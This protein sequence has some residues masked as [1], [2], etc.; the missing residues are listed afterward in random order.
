PSGGA[1]D[2][3]CGLHERN[4][5]L[6]HLPRRETDGDRGGDQRDQ[7]DAD[8]AGAD[9]E[10]GVR[11][12]IAAFICLISLP[13]SAE[14]YGDLGWD[15]PEEFVR[16][17]QTH[18]QSLSVLSYEEVQPTICGTY[19]GSVPVVLGGNQLSVYCA[20]FLNAGLVE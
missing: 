19:Q 15:Y 2:G 20:H 18:N 14:E 12:W 10:G 11:D 6:P 9:G 1:G 8:R 7:A 3:R 4:P 5:G 16:P 17:Y 13:C